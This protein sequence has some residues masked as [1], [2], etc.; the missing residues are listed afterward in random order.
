MS[1]LK[2]N[3]NIKCAACVATVTPFL[4][5]EPKIKHWEVDLQD[6]NRPLKVETDLS[7]KE[8]EELV[9]KAGYQATPI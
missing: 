6:P 2:F 4:A 5:N 1:T 3:S 7:A 9:K 8:V